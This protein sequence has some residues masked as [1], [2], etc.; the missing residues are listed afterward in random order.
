MLEPIVWRQDKSPH[1]R[2]TFNA[3]VLQGNPFNSAAGA[4]LGTVSADD[5]TVIV[6]LSTAIVTK[7]APGDSLTLAYGLELNIQQ[8]TRGA[9]DWNLKCT[10]NE[11][12]P[13]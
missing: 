3:A 1:T 10:A 7:F 6:P 13:H 2:G 5:W 4:S 12:S 9:T 8:I 11:R